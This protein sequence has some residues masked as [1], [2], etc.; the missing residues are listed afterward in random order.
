ME[1][2]LESKRELPMGLT[3]LLPTD[4]MTEQ[5]LDSKKELST[6]SMMV[7]PLDSWMELL[8]GPK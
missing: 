3:M 7:L 4:S 1:Q 5:Q 2:P 6:G 8:M